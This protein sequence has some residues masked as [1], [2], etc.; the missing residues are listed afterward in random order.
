M[1]SYPYALQLYSVRDYLEENT[2]EGLDLVK[3]A[4]F[5]YVETAGDYHLTAFK[6]RNLLDASG[7]VPVGMH[8]SYEQAVC[9]TDQIIEQAHTLMTPHVVI[10]WLG[11]ERCPDRES[12]LEAAETMDDAGALLEKEGLTLCY[13]NHAHEFQHFGDETIFDLIFNNSDPDN[14]KIELD[15]GWASVANADIY[16][17]LNRHRNRIPLVHVK[18]CILPDAGKPAVITELGKGMLDWQSLLPAARDAGA[19]WFIVEQDD[20]EVNTMESAGA[21]ARFMRH[22]NQL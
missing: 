10:A 5:S 21:N 3:E 17:I 14:L 19:Q 15:M 2:A 18:D 4:G 12:W 6:L 11:A 16:A 20:A 7:L 22:F 8:V 13:H 1:M 9:H